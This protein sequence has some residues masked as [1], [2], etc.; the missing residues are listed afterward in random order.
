M[1]IITT[2]DGSHTL[3]NEQF[4]EIYHSRHGAIRESLHVFIK[5][6]LD[7]IVEG[8]NANEVRILEIGFGTGLNA[9]LTML[10]AEKRHLNIDY[11]TLE[12]YPIDIATIKE[13]NYTQQLGYEFC[14]GPYHSLHLVRWNEAHA[15]TPNFTFKKVNES[16]F[17]YELPACKFD[18][19]YFDAFAPDNQPE[20][21]TA[22]TFRKMYAAMRPDGVLVTY[23]SKSIVQRAMREAGLVVEKLPGPPGKR[24]MLRA[25]KQI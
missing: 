13:L 14:Y 24:E 11:T 15:V 9:L 12:L 2:Q 23:C 17:T 18:I 7:Y 19:I 10:E 16:V 21:W 1:Q 6:G 4:N 25:M 5:Q 8:A 22:D 3:F 20:M